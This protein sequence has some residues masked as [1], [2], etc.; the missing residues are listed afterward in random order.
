LRFHEKPGKETDFL[1]VGEKGGGKKQTA[2]ALGILIYEG[3]DSILEQF[4]FLKTLKKTPSLK[5]QQ[6]TNTQKSLF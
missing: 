5:S 1:L 3:R 6:F 4:P 2:E